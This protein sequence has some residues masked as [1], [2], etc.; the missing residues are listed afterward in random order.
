MKDAAEKERQQAE[1]LRQKVDAMLDVVNAASQGDLT[2]DVT[3]S[4]D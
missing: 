4:S 1:E 2:R 3:V